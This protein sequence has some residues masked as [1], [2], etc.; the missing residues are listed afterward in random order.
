MLSNLLYSLEGQKYGMLCHYQL[1]L[2][3]VY[4]S[5]KESFL[6]FSVNCMKRPTHVFIVL[7]PYAKKSKYGDFTSLTVLTHL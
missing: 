7:P 4:P 2:P 5:S 3:L 6:I 1:R